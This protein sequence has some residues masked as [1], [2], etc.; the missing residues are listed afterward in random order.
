MKLSDKL[1]L[2]SSNINLLRFVSACAVI[3]CHS[4]A[5]AEG[6]ED[7][8]SRWFTGQTNLGG[9]AVAVFFFLSGLY[10]TGSLKKSGSNYS[11]MKKRCI[12]IFPQLWIVV[13][14]SV[15]ILGPVMTTVHP[16]EYF[17]NSMTVKYLLNMFLIPAHDLPGVFQNNAVSTVNG[18]LWTMPVE[19]ACYI[20]LV[21]A[22][23]ILNKAKQLTK[24]DFRGVL[25]LV[26]TVVLLLADA[27]LIL[28]L[29][30]GYL[31][32]VLRPVICFFI[33]ALY[34]VYSNRIVLNPL[35]GVIGCVILALCRPNPLYHFT[36]LLILP[37]AI[38]SIC[39]GLPQIK[40]DFKIFAI[41]YEMY[42]VGWP[43]QQVVAE[44]F[45]TTTAYTNF[46]IA[47]P[48]DILLGWCVY[49]LTEKLLSISKRKQK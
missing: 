12:R 46:L 31:A 28:V 37:Y 23:I 43:I 8:I 41:S 18:S 39:L 7:F 20:V 21:L 9:I 38:V 16:G 25:Y 42:L 27:V 17:K 29:K 24:K 35:A 36:V 6:N 26:G 2:R 30:N 48:F 22:E 49:W 13:V 45:H 10:V 44:V 19:F 15:C 47:I 32:N 3:I 34:N 1:K 5:I 40:H 4:Y 33:G 14:L 11:F